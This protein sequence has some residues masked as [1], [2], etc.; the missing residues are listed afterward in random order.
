MSTFYDP[1]PQPA[2][3][4]AEFASPQ[5]TIK[6]S[7]WATPRPGVG[8][9]AWATPQAS[10]R[11]STWATPRIETE[12]RPQFGDSSDTGDPMG[13]VRRMMGLA[14]DPQSYTRNLIK[15]GP[16]GAPLTLMDHIQNL[17]RSPRSTIDNMIRQSL[18]EE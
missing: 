11:P 6:P 8:T 16:G 13:L 9:T 17:A 4:A 3:P 1:F 18:A 2:L 10:I 15:Q 14:H 5:A 12:V 7:V